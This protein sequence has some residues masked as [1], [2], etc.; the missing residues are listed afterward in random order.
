M[1]LVPIPAALAVSETRFAETCALVKAPNEKAPD[2]MMKVAP[3]RVFVSCCVVARNMMYPIMIMGAPMMK[4]MFRRS[5][6]VER[7]GN[8]T[9]KKAP[10]T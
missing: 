8:R 2:A 6:F 10:T 1:T 5:S 9:V 7:S 4:K 3:Y